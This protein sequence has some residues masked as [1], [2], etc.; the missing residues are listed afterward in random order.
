MARKMKTMDGNQAAAHVSYA[1]T[2]VAAIYP[3]TPSS[4]MPEHIDEWATEGRKN[5]FGTTVHVTEMQSEAGAAGAVHGSLAAGALTTTFTASQGLLLMIPNLYKVAGEQLPGVF[6]VSA[7]ALAS[8][9][10]SI[11]GDH[12]DVYACRQTGAAM[13][14]ESSVQEVMDLTPVAHCAALEGKIPFINF[15]DGFRTSHEIQK[16]ETWD[17]EDL[18]DLVNKDAI[19]EF[20]AHALN[21]NHPCQRGSAQNPDIFFQAREACNPYY[22]ALPAIVQNYMDKVNE[23][24]GT[25]YKLFNYY[26]AEDA[27][28]VIVAMGSVCDTIEETIDYLMAAGEKVGVVKVRLYRPFSAEA[29]INAIPDSVKKISVLDRTKEPGA[30][31]EPL[32][33]DVVAALKGTKFDAVPI[34]TGRYG[35]G[36]KDTTPAQ[37]VAVYHNDEKQKFTIGIEDDVTHL[38][39]KA[40]EPLVTTP[41][42]T[43]NCKFWGLGADGTV[44]ANKNSIKIIGD[45]TDM[46]AQA[47]FDYDSKKSG[48]V[49]MSHLRFGKSP[50]KST[51]LIRQA[52]FVACHNPSYVDKYNMVQE[53]VDGGTF[54]LNCSWDMEGLEEHLPGQV[55]SYIAN[56]NIKFYTIDGIKIGKEIGLG[57][58]INTVL[59]SAFFK[60]AAIIPEEEA[61]DL[62]KAAAKA[63]YGRK[64]DKIVQMNYDAIDAG[65]KQVVEIA[66][67]ES[68]KDAADEGLTTPHVG[69]GGRADVVDF[70]KNIQAKVNAQEGNTLPVS[71]FN[72]YVDGSTQSGSSAYEKRGIAVDIPIWQPDNCIQCNRC[73]YVCPHA[74]IR[75]IALTEEEAANAPEGMDM[76]DMMGMPNMKFSIAVSAYDCTGCG[77]CANVCPGKKGEKAL[78]MGNMEANAGKQD[79]FNYGTE[80]PIKPEVVAKFKETTVKGSQ[81]KQPL[82]EFSGACA[83][84]G[85]TPYA[86][87][88]TQLFGDRMYIAN[89]TGCSSIWGNS[90]PSTPYTVNPQGRGPAWSNSLF[91]DN[92]EF[93]YGMLLA[94]NT[95]RERLKASVEKLAE[96]GVNDDVK[97]AAQEYLDTFSVGATN[98]TATDKLVKALEDCDCGCAERAE[99]LKNKDFLAKKS[100]WIFGGDGWAYDIGFGGVDH[101]LASGQDINIMV[102]DTEVYSNTGGQSS[103]AT[104]TGATAQFAAGGKETKKKDLAG[105]AMS[106]GYV[107]VAQIAMGADF[108][109]T[110]KAIAEA[111][112]YPGPSLIIAYAPCIN[113]GIKKGMSKA[114]TEEQLAVECGYWNNFRFNPEAEKKFTLDSKE[115]KG[116]Y[117]EFLNGEV[118][119]NAL[120]RANP[121]KAQRLFAQNEAEAMERYEYLKGLVNLY[122]GTAKED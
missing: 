7:R 117:Q 62:M 33:L 22:D 68:W 64:G 97:A 86:K 70:V 72:E 114:Q 19:D 6:N 119:Y 59:Q 11:F 53:L 67:P 9:A 78:V 74:V 71:A 5:I 94:Q 80:L 32:Y 28:H 26:G 77:S 87:L 79:F 102:F 16:I 98:G 13:L 29:L 12:S 120:M 49:T 27:E 55:K 4:V 121:E 100:Q 95:I 99:L 17:Y 85:E 57:G 47:Y 10:L 115:P 105:I 122:D 39:L 109:Q 69:E 73:A 38:S 2:E 41:E 14:C 52:N 92:A 60:L 107:Y 18:E 1:Y 37:I 25:D 101:V 113:H 44:G 84:C 116:D 65:A 118:R 89:A 91:E 42:G 75:P 58:R 56:H 8:H 110:V 30:L 111:E 34:Y 104:K 24:I 61:I 36:S 63:T 96:N 106:Y 51:Y 31:G 81:F 54:L 88:I 90:S 76:I 103:K 40:D 46:Y 35:L 23:K 112:A 45:N 48:G 83:G 66:V 43:I 50:I 15:F 93:G 82:L 108:N 20:R 21:P 3:I